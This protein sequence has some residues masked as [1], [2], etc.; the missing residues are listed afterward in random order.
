MR[1]TSSGPLPPGPAGHRV[2]VGARRPGARIISS[3]PASRPTTFR[4]SA[5]FHGTAFYCCPAAASASSARAP[6]SIRGIE[7]CPSW[8]AYSHMS[9]S[10]RSIGTS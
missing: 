2:P 8:Q 5:P 1:L 6:P 4:E 3:G 7:W 9:S 10:S